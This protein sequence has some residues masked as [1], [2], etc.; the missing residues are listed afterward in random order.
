MPPVT[1]VPESGFRKILAS[2]EFKGY[3][4]LIFA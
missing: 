1:A 4:R 2:P 3:I